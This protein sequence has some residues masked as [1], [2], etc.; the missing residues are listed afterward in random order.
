MS[1]QSRLLPPGDYHARAVISVDG[2][3]ITRSSGPFRIT[4]RPPRLRPTLRARARRERRA[5]GPFTVRSRRFPTR[6]RADAAGRGFFVDR[7]SA[8]E[9]S[10]RCRRTSRSTRARADSIARSKPRR[11]GHALATAFLQG[12]T[13]YAR[14]D[15]EAAVVK[16]RE[17]LR[18]DS[19]FF[20][21]AFYMGACYAA[22]G[23]DRDASAA[24]QTSLVSETDAPFVYT[25]L[26]D[27]CSA[28]AQSIRRS[29][30][31]RGDGRWPDD[32]GIQMRLGAALAMSGKSSEALR[33][34]DAYLEK[35]PGDA[36]QLFLA[37]RVIYEAH[38]ADVP[39]TRQSRTAPASIATRP[40]TPPPRDP[41]WRWSSSGRSSWHAADS[42]PLSLIIAPLSAVV[43]AVLTRAPGRLSNVTGGQHASP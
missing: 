1:C 9:S 38:A 43:S 12:L 40:P 23:R 42:S 14:G 19:E 5:A 2:R 16:F 41:S 30:P 26:G 11:P 34:L 13:L 17:S 35:H 33:V 4:R 24:W 15:L 10:A 7:M 32:P 28:S 3:K 36:E 37:L 22:G 6:H 21:A 20:P 39:S 29:S 31:Q 18:I 8:G 25:L 27:A